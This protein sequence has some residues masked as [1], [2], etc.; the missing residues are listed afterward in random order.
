MITQQLKVDLRRTEAALRITQDEIAKAFREVSYDERLAQRWP[1]MGWFWRWQVRRG[2]AH[3][4]E[5]IQRQVTLEREVQ[6]LRRVMQA[7]EE[8]ASQ[9]PSYRPLGPEDME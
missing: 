8:D 6:Q 4:A 1:W 7:L 2:Q 9:P 5:L 3:P